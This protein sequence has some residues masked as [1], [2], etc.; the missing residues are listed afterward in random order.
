M[1]TIL[2]SLSVAF[3]VMF[4]TAAIFVLL[5]VSPRSTALKNQK[6]IIRLLYRA[7]PKLA[8]GGTNQIQSVNLAD[9]IT[10]LPGRIASCIWIQT[11]GS[12]STIQLYNHS[13]PAG[14]R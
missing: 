7:Y 10:L 6:E 13:G 12:N 9:R 3:A 8:P 4:G 2:K 11:H 5:F 1:K 14:W